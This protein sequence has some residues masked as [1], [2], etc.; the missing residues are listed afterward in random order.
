M[1]LN[2]FGLLLS[3]PVLQIWQHLLSA[4][5]EDSLKWNCITTLI[6]DGCAGNKERE[7]G[8]IT[9]SQSEM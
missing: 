2:L 7:R 6:S 3:G 5:T 1:L 9:T 4:E 8:T